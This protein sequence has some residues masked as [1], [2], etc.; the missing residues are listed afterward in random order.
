M[1]NSNPSELSRIRLLTAA[2]QLLVSSDENQ[3]SSDG[4]K[5]LS[6]LNLSSVVKK[7]LF[8]SG[9]VRSLSPEISPETTAAEVTE[10]LK[11]VLQK[12]SRNAG[13]HEFSDLEYAGLEAIVQLTGRPA[14]RYDD[15]QVE[16]P[17]DLGENS[18]WRVLVAMARRKINTVS[19]SVGR[20]EVTNST[21]AVQLLGTAW[22]LGKNS[23]VTNRHVVKYMVLDKS[24]AV[25]DWKLDATKTVEINFGIA[26]PG[27]SPRKFRLSEIGYCA[28]E[29]EIDFAVLK[30]VDGAAHVVP[31]ALS[32]DLSTEG[33]GDVADGS[34]GSGNGE[35]GEQVYVV[36]HPYGPPGADSISKVFG[37]ADG[38]K[39]W[40]PGYVT[41]IH[42]SDF[43]FEHDCSTLGGNSG[44]CVLAAASHV[45]VG[46]HFGGLRVDNFTGIGR[47][48]VAIAFSRLK[49][50]PAR[51][52]LRTGELG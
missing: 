31:P 34:E 6:E 41:G 47:S 8:G 49:N 36:G 32:I 19:G 37:N 38:S 22:R 29:G 43:L 52:I 50:A 40:S 27:G 45:V 9:E 2:K 42:E 7:H 12:V 25:A 51:E 15:G 28:P 1:S 44:S 46:L 39:R 33:L 18:V 17:N 4:G 48:N 11:G 10:H 30:L 24:K 16:M 3:E 23:V 13:A 21:G 5:P 14:M 20:V 26:T 35:R